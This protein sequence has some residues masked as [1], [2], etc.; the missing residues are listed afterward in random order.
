MARVSR[1]WTRA[2]GVTLM[3][4]DRAAVEDDPALVR[5]LAD[6]VDRG[7]APLVPAFASHAEWYEVR[8][9]GVTVGV[10]VLQR[11]LPR[12]GTA[13]LLSVATV[14]EHRGRSLAAK[15]LLA[16]ERRLAAEGQ[17]PMLARVARTNGRGLY[18]LLRCGY[19]ALRGDDRPDDPDDVTWFARVEAS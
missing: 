16:T 12:A 15:A 3:R 7:G 2:L 18:F 4:T 13:T 17:S 1:V 10:A 19:T 5:A 9:D 14:R 11:D 6:G 8:A